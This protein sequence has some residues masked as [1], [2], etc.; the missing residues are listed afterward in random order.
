MIQAAPNNKRQN[1]QNYVHFSQAIVLLLSLAGLGISAYL[2][3]LRSS[4]GTLFCAGVGDCER[5]QASV[6]AEMAGIP[7]AFL[8]LLVY[9]S[10]FALGLWQTLVRPEAR[11]IPML[12]TFGLSLVGM[13]YSA[14]LTYIELF[15]IQAVC[16]WCVI[17]ALVFS[18]IFLLVLYQLV[19]LES[20]VRKK[21]GKAGEVAP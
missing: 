21:N 17:S 4:G 15:V 11:E 12:A 8:G 18:A 3:Y 1:A 16:F 20:V 19:S 6:Y 14:Y 10:L 9:M 13:L 5:V 2:S 7:V